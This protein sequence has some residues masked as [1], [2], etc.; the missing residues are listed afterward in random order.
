MSH[1]ASI[2][3]RNISPPAPHA[4]CTEKNGVVKKALL[5][6]SLPKKFKRNCASVFVPFVKL[7]CFFVDVFLWGRIK[8]M[9][10]P[11]TSMR[12]IPKPI[13]ICNS[14][15]PGKGRGVAMDVRVAACLDFPRI[16]F[17]VW[18]WSRILHVWGV[19]SY[20]KTRGQNHS[21]SLSCAFLPASWH[22]KSKHFQLVMRFLH[23]S[24]SR[25]RPWQQCY[26]QIC[27]PPNLNDP[28]Q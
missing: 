18:G 11:K 1:V 3:M 26:S 12:R 7:P 17:Q 5:K 25:R 13:Q 23:D 19:F 9:E 2:N 8:M 21:K 28:K 14:Q 10:N 16:S 24:L 27:W 22:T 15:E 4:I 20:W 6:D